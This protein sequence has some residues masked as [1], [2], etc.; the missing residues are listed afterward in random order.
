MT[1]E[2]DQHDVDPS[3]DDLELASA[4]RSV[5]DRYDGTHD[6]SNATLQRALFRT[7]KRERK[8]KVVRWFVLPAAAAL[9]ASTAWAGVTGRLPT[10]RSMLD[11][12]YAS[13]PP[14]EEH[15]ERSPASPVAP[16]ASAVTPAPTAAPLAVND[17]APE[18]RVEEPAPAPSVA[19]VTPPP[20]PPPVVA[21]EPKPAPLPVASEP[22]P[23]PDVRDP[24]PAPSAAA[25]PAPS[26]SDPHAA[27][28]AE[29]HRI[30]FNDKDPA[31]ALAAWDRYLAAAPSG[32]FAPEARYN[33]A[34]A[35]VRLGRRV[36][37]QQELAVFAN[38][39]YGDYR[40]AEAKALLDALT[41]DAH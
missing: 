8:Q 19:V 16:I 21:R 40:R 9:L 36:E 14:W 31:R 1:N 23:T 5:R 3:N 29:A 25:A 38:G 22:A 34:I 35:L 15:S 28:F 17:P 26:A 30:H 11:A 12:V 24:A 39:M 20:P 10:V 33:R 41:H 13:P 7:R 4:F 2:Q 27:L 37:A 32:R 18:P 6:E